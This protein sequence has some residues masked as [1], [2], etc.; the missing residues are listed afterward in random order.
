MG[1]LQDFMGG[2][3]RKDIRN[4]QKKA[5]ADLTTGYNAGQDYNNQAYDTM[6]P[7]ANAATGDQNT[8]RQAIGLGTP[9]EQAAAQGR[10]F[11]DPAMKAVL[12]DQSNA[13]LRELNARGASGGGE[14]MMAAGKL[15]LQNYGNW[16]NR[17]QGL[18]SK[19]G[20]YAGTE[21]GIRMNQGNMAYGYGATKAGMDT[22]YGNAMAASRSTGI[23]NMMGVLNTGIKAAT[24]IA[25]M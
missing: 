7:L 8:Y 22:N 24:A 5:D 25:G 11:N 13:M 2:S 12:A 18:G 19:A 1:F 3:A 23:N 21:A 9:E 10:Y 14:A 6:A 17:L 15:G 4:A 20:E 16:L